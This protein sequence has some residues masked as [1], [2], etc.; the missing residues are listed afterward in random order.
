MK[1]GRAFQR[2]GIMETPDAYLLESPKFAEMFSDV[3]FR[4]IITEVPQEQPAR[5]FNQ[6]DTLL[7]TLRPHINAFT[8]LFSPGGSSV[9]MRAVLRLGRRCSSRRRRR[10]PF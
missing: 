8:R 4:D 3:V 1:G 9:I 6:R 7:G 10:R 5:L 2:K